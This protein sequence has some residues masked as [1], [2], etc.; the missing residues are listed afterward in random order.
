MNT[1]PYDPL[2][3][4]LLMLLLICP[5]ECTAV[6][7]TNEMCRKAYRNLGPPFGESYPY[8]YST[9]EDALLKSHSYLEELRTI[10]LSSDTIPVDL[11]LG[12]LA[13]NVTNSNREWC[14]SYP[15]S[16]TFCPPLYPHGMWSVCDNCS[17]SMRFIQE[18][19]RNVDL[20]DSKEKI[21]SSIAFTS[22]LHGYLLSLYMPFYIFIAGDYDSYNDDIQQGIGFNMETLLC[23]P[24]CALTQ[25]VLSQLL[26]WVCETTAS[27][28]S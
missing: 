25:C 1:S 8:L 10:F 14:F 19:L 21:S 12:L 26:S 18:T 4:T 15:Y 7:Q 11:T 2:P 20:E 9:F 28:C 17:L 16:P 22:L 3:F 23:N 5:W 13:L 27:H 24:S 6:L